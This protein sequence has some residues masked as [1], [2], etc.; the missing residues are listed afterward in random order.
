MAGEKEADLARQQNRQDLFKMGVHAIGIEEG[1]SYGKQGW[2]IVA[3]ISP[4]AK[5]EL[6]PSVS[7]HS[8]QAGRGSVPLVVL[9]SEPFKPE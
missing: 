3:H 5:V 9:R 2:V 1:K 8:Q 6:P 7:Y 4:E